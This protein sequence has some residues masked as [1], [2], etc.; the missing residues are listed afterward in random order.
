MPPRRVV[1]DPCGGPPERFAAACN[2]GP[3]P[4]FGEQRFKVEAHLIDFH[5]DLYDRTI[6][7]DFLERIRPTRA[8][9]G[10]DDLLEQ[11]RRDVALAGRIVADLDPISPGGGPR[12][13]G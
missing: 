10:L 4:T 6:G 8:F 7:L 13:T 3:N 1:P 2:I 12:N 5:G 11:I 9:A